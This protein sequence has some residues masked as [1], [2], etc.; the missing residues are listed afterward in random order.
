MSQCRVVIGLMSALGSIAVAADGPET[1]IPEVVVTGK[2]PAAQAA[3]TIS[4]PIAD[5]RFGIPADGGDLLR[6]L[7]GVDGSRMGGHG[8]DPIVRGQSQNQL[9]ILIDGAHAF[10]GC[11]NRMDPPT[12]LLDLE[13]YDSLT[14]IKSAQTVRHGG[15]GSGGTI[16][17]E[18]H[19]PRFT[20]GEAPRARFNGG[21]TSNSQTQSVGADIAIGNPLAFARVT[22]QSRGANNYRDGHGDEVRSAYNSEAAGFAI[23]YT[24]SDSTRIEVKYDTTHDWDVLFAGAAMDSPY[25]NSNQWRVKFDQDVA[26][27]SLQALRAELYSVNVDH[28]MDNYSLR[29]LTG[30]FK[31]RAPT[32][33]NT[34]GGRFVADLATGDTD[35]TLGVDYLSV[36]RDATR[37]WNY[38][39]ASVDVPQ[40]Y[41]WPDVVQ[42]DLGFFVE[43]E[44][45]LG[46][47]ARL[48]AGLRYDQVEAS[49]SKS[50]ANSAPVGPTWLMSPNQLYSAY[51]GR[52]A[53]DQTENNLGGFL[54]YGLEFGQGL[55][56]TAG[57]SR[58][59]RTADATE[60]YLA[61][62]G[63]PASA[64]WVGNPGLRPEQHH[65]IDLS[66]HKTTATWSTG[67]E[68]FHD[69]VDD[70]ILRDRA[71]GQSGILLTDNA[72][73]YRNVEADLTGGE[74]TVEIQF[75]PRWQAG[76]SLAYVQARNRSDERAIAQIPPLSGQLKLEHRRDS[77]SAGARATWAD[78]QDRVDDDPL[79][80]SGL[81]VGKT[82]GWW[83]LDLYGEASIG[84]HGRLRLG[85]DN[86]FDRAYA[87]HVNRA[88]LDPFN[89][90]A[91]QVN[92]PGRMLWVRASLDF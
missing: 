11:P 46:A 68:I 33:S 9:N 83:V 19:T 74:W 36:A 50:R 8:L 13:A 76:A 45:P 34:A 41:L 57:A 52:S 4:S 10:G 48:T 58:S 64:R 20:E 42:D 51:Y 81:D 3:G 67:L 65:Q 2:R 66:L 80:G 87:Y 79:T 69:R 63:N 37:Y 92:E 47:S 89:P 86:L 27:G 14:L 54:R 28:L 23:G 30:L 6:R 49:L 38:K 18:R 16:L 85:I 70:Y 61:A 40:S 44:R 35:W 53:E 72:T 7:P 24:P 56:L 59:L 39:S 25:S 73:I 26:M 15:G 31:M 78:T 32:E 5:A 84:K 21:L 1:L 91:V 43:G 17:F 12:T 60:R 71:H 62:N 88:N 29:A 22:G 90:E 77:W 55:A 75:D 82:A